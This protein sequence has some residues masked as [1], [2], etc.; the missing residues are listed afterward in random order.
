M[1]TCAYTAGGAARAAIWP[2]GRAEEYNWCTSWCRCKR[3]ERAKRAHSLY[4][5]VWYY[6]GHSNDTTACQNNALVFTV[7]LLFLKLCWH[8]RRRP[9]CI[10]T[11]THTH[12]RIGTCSLLSDLQEGTHIIIH[13]HSPCTASAQLSMSCATW[14]SPTQCSAWI[15]LLHDG[16]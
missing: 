2:K 3:N 4:S 10:P 5:I 8:I 6:L 11:H 16:W 14:L 13:S 12:I 1:C 9:T 7:C 15:T